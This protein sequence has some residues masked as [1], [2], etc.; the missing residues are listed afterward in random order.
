[1]S[2]EMNGNIASLLAKWRG[3]RAKVWDFSPTHNKLTLRVDRSNTKG[4]IHLICGGCSYM[5]GP[6]SWATCCLDIRPSDSADS[7]IVVFDKGVGFELVCIVLSVEET[8]E[9]VYQT[10]LGNIL[11]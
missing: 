8:V 3:G 4:N 9:P 10:N 11:G 6:F 1:M 2:E 7:K 5:R